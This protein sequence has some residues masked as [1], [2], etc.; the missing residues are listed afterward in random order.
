[1]REALR[2]GGYGDL[3]IFFTP[4]LVPG[5]R[6]ELPFPDPTSEDILNDGCL[7]KAQNDD[8]SDP[9]YG[10]VVIHEVGH[11]LGLLH[12]FDGGCEE[13]PGDYVDDTPAEAFPS[14]DACPEEGRDTCPD[15][16]GL[17]PVDNY[18]TYVPAYVQ[19]LVYA[20]KTTADVDNSD[21]NTLKFTPGQVDR[22]HNLWSELRLPFVENCKS[23]KRSL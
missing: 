22:M 4:Y 20:L 10:K 14:F 15:L 13:G 8:P 9:R 12:T 2:K 7:V 18:M 11:W 6:C 3:N 5:G 23:R 21:C 1:M 16:P 17:D 19:T